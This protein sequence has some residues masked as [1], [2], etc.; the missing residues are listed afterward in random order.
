MRSKI[1]I[2]NF[3][4]KQIGYDYQYGIASMLYHKLAESDI[5]LANELHSHQGFKFYT[6]SNLFLEDRKYCKTGLDFGR[7][8]FFISSPDGRFI[9]SFAEGLLMK[10]DFFLQGMEGR[11]DFGI[12]RIEVL[13]SPDLGEECFFRTISPVYVKT[14]RKD[15]GV[16]KEIDLYP[17][18]P[19]FYE[20]MHNNLR[21]RY[22]E[23]YG[24]PPD[25]DYFDVVGT[26]G[27]KPK[28]IKVSGNFRRCTLMNLE[29]QASPELLRFAYD[30]GLGEKNAMGFGCL[31]V[32]DYS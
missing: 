21:D 14:M 15:N 5:R 25:K 18:D 26:S 24:A 31:D 23:F 30:S 13:A 28:R 16:L 2:T 10:P 3:S 12:E 20:N 1:T 4:G 7:A 11:V 9:R 19:K 22:T 32:V 6:F 27:I 29:I 17:S 8:T